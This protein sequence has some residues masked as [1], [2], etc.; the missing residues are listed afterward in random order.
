LDDFGGRI[1]AVDAGVVDYLISPVNPLIIVA[2]VRNTLQRASQNTTRKEG[3][4]S[5]SR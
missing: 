2:K 5:I 3:I 4:Y 1:A